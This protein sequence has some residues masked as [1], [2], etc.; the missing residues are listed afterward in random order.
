MGP[1]SISKGSHLRLTLD[2]DRASYT[3]GETVSGHVT[4]AARHDTQI[5]TVTASLRGRVVTKVSLAGGQLESRFE[6]EENFIELTETLYQG[7]YTHKAGEFVWPFALEIPQPIRSEATGSVVAFERRPQPTQLLPPARF[8]DAS[9]GKVWY[10]KVEYFV[11]AVLALPSGKKQTAVLPLSVRGRDSDNMLDLSDPTQ[12]IGTMQETQIRSWKLLPEHVTTPTTLR[13]KTAS[14]FQPAS[15]PRF[16]FEIDVSHPGVLQIGNVHHIPFIIA[17]VPLTAS[18]KSSIT[19]TAITFYRY[20]SITVKS[21]SVNMHTKTAIRFATLAGQKSM[22]KETSRPLLSTQHLYRRLVLRSTASDQKTDAAEE[23]IS[24]IDIG[25]LCRMRLPQQDPAETLVPSFTSARLT[26]EHSV[27][28]TVELVCAQER[29]ILH[30]RVPQPITLLEGT[31]GSLLG[32][33]V[34]PLGPAPAYEDEYS[35]SSAEPHTIGRGI[36]EGTDVLPAARGEG[37]DVVRDIMRDAKV[38]T[39]TA[40]V[41]LPAYVEAVEQPVVGTPVQSRLQATGDK[42]SRLKR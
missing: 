7:H 20:P 21:V 13:Q 31:V 28:W 5:G 19:P 29:R 2:H 42:K 26:H 18:D 23:T 24:S 37:S 40:L 3:P 41:G 11:Q 22:I 8:R 34:L 33:N 12:R 38:A 36:G 15:V 14:I 30:S 10:A 27:S 25:L 35:R 6:H 9:V 1:Q 39:E 16:S 4:L 17:A 32:G